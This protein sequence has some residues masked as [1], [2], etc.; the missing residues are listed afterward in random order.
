MSLIKIAGTGK[1]YLSKS[2]SVPALSGVNLDIQ[3]GEFISLIG[4]S[5]CG[6]STLLMLLAGLESATH[7]EILFE[8]KKILGPDKKNGIIFQDATL[9]PWKSVLEN[10]LFPIEILKLDKKAYYKKAHELISIV[11]LDKFIDKKPHEL[12]GGMR[13]RVAICRSLIHDPQVLLMDEPFSAL[14]A[15]TRDQMNIVLSE[16]LEKFNKTVVFVTHSIKEA[17]FLS[18][19]VVV[20]G[21]R[22]AGVTLDLKIDFPRPRRSEIE[23]LDL[24]R[25]YSKTLRQTILQAHQAMTTEVGSV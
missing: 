8:D 11:K 5:G 24:F 4:P 23:D 22:P 2:G 20:L 19:R 7:G 3:S 16:L 9:L 12:S 21:G 13:Q 25:D 10:I 17:I 1:T 15:I 14:D 18:D 6:K